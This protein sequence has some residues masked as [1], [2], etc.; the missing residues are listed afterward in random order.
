VDGAGNGTFAV[1][2]RSAQLDGCRARLYAGGGMV[3]DSDPAAELAET[4][5]KFSA[6][7]GAIVRP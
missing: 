1:A 5:A 2:V 6:L 3:A 7:L 4:R